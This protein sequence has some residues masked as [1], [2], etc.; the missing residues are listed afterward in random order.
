MY[1]M[2]NK[3]LFLFS[4]GVSHIGTK[5]FTFALSWYILSETGSGLSFSISLLVNYLPMILISSFAGY[6]SD[7]VKRPNRVLVLCD[8]MSAAVC[9]LPFLH[10][11]LASVYTSIFLLS[12]ISAVFNNAIDTHLI[13]LE[14][15]DGAQSLKKTSSMS[16]FITASV[17]IAAPSL[18]G[19]MIKIFPIQTFALLNMVSFFLSALGEVFLRFKPRSVKE[20]AQTTGRAQEKPGVFLRNLF[21]QRELRTFLIGDSLG[22]FC[23]SA[24]FN[25]ALPLIVT[26]TLGISSNGYGLI[27][28]SSAAGSVLCAL[29]R[30]KYPGKTEFRYPFAKASGLG[31]S[32][33]ILA[34]IACLPYHA[35]WSVTTLCILKFAVGWLAVDINIQTKT[36]LQIYVDS[37]QLGKALGVSTAISYILIPL[38]LIIGGIMVE[39]WPAYL[40]PAVSGVLLISTLGLLKLAEINS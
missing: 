28:S 11:G 3:A 39:I 24:G 32:M 36:T 2:G 15:L 35:V 10:L 19:V 27:S 1:D 34:L 23:F 12:A 33:L 9:V 37:S 22:N 20:A 7:R 26:V 18:G 6:V 38:S 30:T 40:L 13:N 17:N 25:V 8:L 4:K 31:V 14:G 5:L 16:Q 29:V 21:R